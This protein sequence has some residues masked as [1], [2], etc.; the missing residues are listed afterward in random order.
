[1]S[2]DDGTGPADP[3]HIL[4][5]DDHPLLRQGI[6]R[7]LGREP[8]LEVVGEAATVEE[9][10]DAAR[11][12]KP[13]LIVLDLALGDAEGLDAIPRLRQ[14]SGGALILVLSMFDEAIY[15]ERCLRAGA[16]GYVMKEEA[17][18]VLVEAVRRV[19][20]GEVVV[21]GAVQ[22]RLVR[23]AAGVKD[24]G[25]VE[26]LTDREIQVFLHIGKGRSTR[27]IAEQLHLSVKTVES[28]RA[29][30]MRKLKVDS[31]HQLV[32]RAVVWLHEASRMK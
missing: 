7:V 3:A 6:A 15:A 28:H 26:E 30:I 2:P 24:G 23:K 10:M 9:A 11:S 32:H 21:S 31:A 29:K 19:L 27:E 12:L 22:E 16:T 20:G 25:G 14:A 18:E 5:V 4:L 8:E 13:D 1:M 17:S